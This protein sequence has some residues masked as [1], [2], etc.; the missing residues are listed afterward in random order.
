[1]QFRNEKN[2]YS[3]KEVDNYIKLLEEKIDFQAKEYD[4]IQRKLNELQAKLD[5]YLQK[6]SSIS[7]ALISAVEKANSIELDSKNKYELEI[8][9]VKLL[10]EKWEAFLHKLLQETP[11]LRG[12]FDN[13]VILDSFSQSINQ[14]LQEN[15]ET[16][17]ITNLQN[18]KINSKEKNFKK[19]IIS[20]SQSGEK[21]EY[22]NI[23]VR[24]KSPSEK[25]LNEQAILS[26]HKE[27]TKRLGKNFLTHQ[28]TME[29]FFNNDSFDELAMSYNNAIL[30]QQNHGFDLKEAVNPT[31]DLEDIMKAFDLDD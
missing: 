14:T 29:D 3:K 9:K 7:K 4:C 13:K 16:L 21:D 8:T 22:K 1:M 19:T 17:K 25:T 20:N 15:F 2:G 27:E 5:E 26:R 18:D 10:Y 30:N 28:N 31:E 23:I 11:E 24:K 6:E 12:E